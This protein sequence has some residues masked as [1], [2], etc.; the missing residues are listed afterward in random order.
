MGN[1]VRGQNN[2]MMVIFNIVM[3]NYRI[4]RE[5]CKLKNIDEIVIS[6]M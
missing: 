5:I 1:I 4:L 3:K 2:V 6:L